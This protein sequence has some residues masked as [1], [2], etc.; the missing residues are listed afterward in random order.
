VPVAPKAARGAQTVA[1]NGCMEAAGNRDTQ[2]NTQGEVE[3]SNLTEFLQI[4]AHQVW[5]VGDEPENTIPSYRLAL[6]KEPIQL[7]IVESRILLYL[8]SRPYYS[9]TRRSI[10]NAV[11]T[12]HDPV[13]EDSV[14]RH[15]ASL[16]DQLGVFH[17]YVQAV[18]YVGYR[19]K[20]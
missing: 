20:A 18:P 16:V 7:G 2:L 13:E 9:F 17:D 3:I 8:A 14:D 6:G 12:S 1:Y 11:S 15:V 19:F 4:A 5:P 10:A